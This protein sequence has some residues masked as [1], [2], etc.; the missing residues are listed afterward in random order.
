MFDKLLL[1]DVDGRGVLSLSPGIR[2]LRNNALLVTDDSAQSAEMTTAM[3]LNAFVAIL[4]IYVLYC[5]R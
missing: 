3:L 1:K 2:R 5:I 4:V